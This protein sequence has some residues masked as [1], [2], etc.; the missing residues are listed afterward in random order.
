MLVEALIELLLASIAEFL[1]LVLSSVLNLST[2]LALV[3]ALK[4]ELSLFFNASL[5]LVLASALV[6][7]SFDLCSLAFSL[8]SFSL[9]I[10]LLSDVLCDL[11][12]LV[13]SEFFS[14]K[15]VSC[16]ASFSLALLKLFSNDSLCSALVL[17]KLSNDLAWLVLVDV[18]SEATPLID[19]LNDL[20][21]DLL[22]LSSLAILND[23]ARLAL[24]LTLVEFSVLCLFTAS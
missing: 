8:A 12:V 5:A 6:C 10:E 21:I 20:L 17:F 22:K 14:L 13:A 23:L 2:S 18:L 1:A 11:L 24:I 7:D 16:D 4:L 9:V 15:L 3:D 19:V